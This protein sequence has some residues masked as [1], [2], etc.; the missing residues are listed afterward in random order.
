MKNGKAILAEL[1]EKYRKTLHVETEN[2][3]LDGGFSLCLTDDLTIA[4]L[5]DYD[6]ALVSILNEDPEN[7]TEA[8]GLTAS[9]AKI[10]GCPPYCRYEA[11]PN[12]REITY[13]LI[14][15]NHNLH[16]ECFSRTYGAVLC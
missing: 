13:V 16:L 12:E 11:P 4:V 10:F 6:Y 5:F 7:T 2:V 9:L 3:Y 8:D 15:K 14:E 1:K